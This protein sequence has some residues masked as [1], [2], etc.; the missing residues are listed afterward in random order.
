M[1]RFEK[2]SIFMIECSRTDVAAIEVAFREPSIRFCYWHFFQPLGIQARN[3]ICVASNIN[4]A[5]NNFTSQHRTGTLDKFRDK[6]LKYEL[7]YAVFPSWMKHLKSQ[8]MRDTPKWL[9][10]YRMMA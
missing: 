7:R 10:G 5:L 2:P 4:S 3:K 9:G 8:W 1:V 6:F